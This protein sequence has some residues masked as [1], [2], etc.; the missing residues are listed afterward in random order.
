MPGTINDKE[1]I[2]KV[3]SG[4]PRVAVIGASSKPD[5]ASNVVA[6]FLASRGFEI[7]P[8]NPK[9]S[10][11]L[12]RTCY[13]SLEDVPGLVDV[14]DVFR[15]PEDIGPIVDAAIRKQVSVLWLQLGVINE[16]EARRAADAGLDVVMD[17]CI[18]REMEKIETGASVQ[19][20]EHPKP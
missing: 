6:G 7:V 14:A 10:Q 18:K 13:P 16:A 8:V 2:E 3:I 4:K 20:N 17:H 11:I 12:G 5:R 1:V 15:K 19:E 9:E